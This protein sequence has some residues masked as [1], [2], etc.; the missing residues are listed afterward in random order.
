MP[1]NGSGK[2]SV[3]LTRRFEGMPHTAKP[4]RY[5]SRFV[6]PHKRTKSITL[7]VAVDAER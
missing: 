1:W 3:I 5:T 4:C 6:I 2:A 7:S